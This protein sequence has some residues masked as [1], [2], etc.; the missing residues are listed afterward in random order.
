MPDRGTFPRYST[1]RDAR[2]FAGISA[3]ATQLL[4]ADPRGRRSRPAFGRARAAERDRRLGRQE[5]LGRFARRCPRAGAALFLVR[6]I[7]RRPE[8]LGQVE[9]AG[10]VAAGKLDQRRDPAF[11][12]RVGGEQVGEAL[13]RIVDAHFHDGGGGAFQFAAALDLAQ[14]RDHGVGVLGQFDRAGVGEIFALARQREADHHREQPG[15]RDQ[16]DG[17]DDRDAGAALAAVAVAGGAAA[18]P[19]PA[20]L[21]HHAEQQFGEEADNAGDDHGDHQH[22]HV[23]VADMGQLV[24]EH[25][26]DLGVVEVV[27]QAGASP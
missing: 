11:D 24:A 10:I 20:A 2:G 26:L 15:H 6:R 7:L 25:R 1:A 23:A 16:R 12:R 14:R 13:A 5:R 27:E 22:A 4:A 17:D 9:R 3:R 19:A 21:E 8:F 18:A